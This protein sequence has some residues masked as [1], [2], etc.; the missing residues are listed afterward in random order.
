MILNGD[1][2]HVLETN[3]I[4]GLTDVSLFPKAANAMG[5][6]FSQVLEHLIDVALETHRS[7]KICTDR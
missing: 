4:P 5:M 1:S 7:K 6:S 3:T 2:L